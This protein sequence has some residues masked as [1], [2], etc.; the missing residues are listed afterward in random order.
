MGYKKDFG[1]DREDEIVDSM[2]EDLRKAV[3][4][5]SMARLYESNKARFFAEKIKENLK[6]MDMEF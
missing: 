1:M 2:V 5:V 3:Q 4:K 6:L